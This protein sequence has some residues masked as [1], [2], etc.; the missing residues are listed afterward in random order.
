[1]SM[2]LYSIVFCFVCPAFSMY[3]VFVKYISIQFNTFTYYRLIFTYNGLTFIYYGLT[4]IHY[5]LTFIHYGF[6][7]NRKRIYYISAHWLYQST[8]C[9]ARKELSVLSRLH[10]NYFWITGLAAR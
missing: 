9:Y 7:F 2:L 10:V 3:Y 5:G 6:T 1:M 4:F 8:Y